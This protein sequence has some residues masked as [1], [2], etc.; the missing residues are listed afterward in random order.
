MTKENN[1]P[2]TQLEPLELTNK[3]ITQDILLVKKT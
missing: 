2:S 1:M 3:N